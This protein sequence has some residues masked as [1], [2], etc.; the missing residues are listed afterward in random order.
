M[1]ETDVLTAL[2]QAALA[3]FDVSSLF[4]LSGWSK[5]TRVKA[6]G[7]TFTIPGDNRYV[8]LVNIPNN[9]TND[10]W[11]G[12]RVYQ[13]NFRIILHWNIDDSGVYPPM[14]YLDEIASYFDK[15]KIFSS[16][17]ANVRIYDFPG[18]SNMI[19]AGSEL[20]FPLTLPYRCFRP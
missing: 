4:A 10:Y 17:A 11:N 9:R 3:A 2:Q 19:A 5:E 6:M 7:R 13:G 8:E 18:A 15:G 1:I 16:G 14:T 20:L 12:E